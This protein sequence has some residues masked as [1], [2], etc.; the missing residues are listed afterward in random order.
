M[1]CGNHIYGSFLCTE[2]GKETPKHSV[3]GRNAF[4]K[5]EKHLCLNCVA[6]SRALLG[7]KQKLRKWKLK[8]FYMYTQAMGMEASRLKREREYR[9]CPRSISEEKHR[10]S[11][12]YS[13]HKIQMRMKIHRYVENLMLKGCTK[14]GKMWKLKG[15]CD[16]PDNDGPTYYTYCK[17]CDS[18]FTLD[19]NRGGAICIA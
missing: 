12:L 15:V 11:P 19:Y 8:I 4:E 10:S 18:G 16:G 2:C 6:E 14:C 7:R 9:N 1:S 17:A 5:R 13:L 3:S